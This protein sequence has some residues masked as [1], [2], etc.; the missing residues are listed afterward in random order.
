MFMKDFENLM[1][2]FKIAAKH[3]KKNPKID[4]MLKYRKAIETGFI[5]S[6]LCMTIV[7]FS[8]RKFDG[9]KI[10]QVPPEITIVIEDIPQTAH[11][12]APPPPSRPAIPI[13]SEDDELMDDV[14]IEDTEIQFTEIPPPP[15]PPKIEEDDNIPPFLPFEAQPK[16]IG[17]FEALKKRIKYPDLAIVAKVEGQAVVRTLV[18][19]NG[20]PI[21][22]QILK[23]PGAGC[24]KAVIDAL[25]ETKF[26]PAMQRDRPVKFWINVPIDFQLVEVQKKGL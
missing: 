22:F 20:K 7:F 21:D 24:A 4:L 8:F 23:D 16:I 26:T 9:Q 13:A 11:V 10:E 17:G 18:N 3:A 14:T 6:L 2:R 19:E 25:K 12:K 5:V 15:P 1:T